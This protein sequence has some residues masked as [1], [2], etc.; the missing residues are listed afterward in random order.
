ME[1]F[2]LPRHV[3]LRLWDFLRLLLSRYILYE[4]MELWVT[5]I[6]LAVSHLAF[7]RTSAPPGF[8][9]SG[10]GLWFTKSANAWAKE[11]LPVGNGYLA[12]T[13]LAPFF[14]LSPDSR[15]P[16]YRAAPRMK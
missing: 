2:S 12:G 8:P 16:W 5:R 1:L 4:S 3:F 9:A 14:C 6:L 7:M 15:K 13:C 11:W 10:N